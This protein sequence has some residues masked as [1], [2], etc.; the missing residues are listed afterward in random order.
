MQAEAMG[1][2]DA[3]LRRHPG[4]WV[5]AYG[6]FARALSPGAGGGHGFL[7]PPADKVW[8]ARREERNAEALMRD[9]IAIITTEAV[10]EGDLRRSRVDLRF[11]HGTGSLPLFAAIATRLA[12]ARDA[13]P[14]VIS[15]VGHVLYVH[16]DEAAAYIARHALA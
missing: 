7:E 11:S 8:Y 2:M 3:Y 1:V 15:G 6:A 9:D 13:R 5:G 4:D 14:E 16:P 10:D 12:E